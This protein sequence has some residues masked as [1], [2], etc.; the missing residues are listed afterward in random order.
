MSDLHL[1]LLR[2]ARTLEREGNQHDFD[3]FLSPVGLQNATRMGIYLKQNSID[4]DIIVSSPADRARKTAELIAEQIKKDT[5]TIHFNEEIY[6]ASV[7]NLLKTVNSLKNMWENVLIV[8]HN[9]AISYLAEYLT[10]EAIGSITTCGL[11]HLT[12]K[13]MSWDMVGEKSG[14]L[15]SYLTP[16]SLNF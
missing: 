16:D 1:Y 5:K 6:E 2:H 7:R 8:G 12:F 15:V 14:N 4:F 9:P 11:V 10:G 13:N 3:R